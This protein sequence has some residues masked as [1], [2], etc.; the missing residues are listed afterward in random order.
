[1]VDFVYSHDGM[2]GPITTSL[3]SGVVTLTV[4]N[5]PVNALA[6]AVLEAL[7]GA[8][9]A[10]AGAPGVRA[11]VIAGAGERSFVAGAD[12]AE[13]EHSLGDSAAMEAHVALTGSVFGALTRLEVPV[14]AAVGGHAVGGGLAEAQALAARLAALPGRAVRSAKAALRASQALPLEEGLKAERRLFLQVARTSDAGE[15]AAAF[16]AKREP[17]FTHS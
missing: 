3:D 2:E 6:D 12:L 15:G 5:P 1:L 13:L 14:V 17:H 7:G 8:L 4:D 16:L 9:A 10:L 11:A